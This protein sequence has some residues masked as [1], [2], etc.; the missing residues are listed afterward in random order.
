[1]KSM[2]CEWNVVGR[3]SA[4]KTVEWFLYGDVPRSR[5]TI[6]QQRKKDR[7]VWVD[8]SKVYPIYHGRSIVGDCSVTPEEI[9][10]LYSKG[11]RIAALYVSDTEKWTETQGEHLAKEAMDR[12]HS[13]GVPKG[14]ILLLNLD[15]GEVM[16]GNCMREFV[17]EVM[18]AGYFPGLLR[19]GRVLLVDS[20]SYRLDGC[21]VWSVVSVWTYGGLP[22][23]SVWMTSDTWV[24]FIPSGSVRED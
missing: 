3:C 17:R 1:M 23:T 8:R 7:F 12:A 24:S 22:D 21:A 6:S 20:V 2:N 5:E 16:D 15:E 9:A 14:S 19:R 13:L 11:C 10:F 18:D 4:N